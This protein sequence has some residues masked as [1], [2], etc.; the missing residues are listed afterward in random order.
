PSA[1]TAFSAAGIPNYP[2]ESEAVSGFM[3]LV[4]YREAIDTLMAMPPSL[5]QDFAPDVATANLVIDAA[6]RDRRTW[7][8]PLE[9]TRLLNAY[10]IPITPATLAHDAEEAVKAARPYLAQ[11]KAVV[12]KVLSPDIVHKSEV[13]GVRLN[14]T[15]ESAVHGATLEILERA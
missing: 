9:I 4:R 3:H 11:G 12:V 13:G 6:L 8:D 10:G 15:N 7:L 1:S 2:T 5:P 14:L